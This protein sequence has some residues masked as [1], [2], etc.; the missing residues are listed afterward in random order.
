MLTTGGI[1]FD[2][3]NTPYRCRIDDTDFHFSSIVYQS[4]F[5]QRVQEN[6]EMMNAQLTVKT[7]IKTDFNLL[8][9]ISLYTRIEKRG[10]YIVV[11]GVEYNCKEKATLHGERVSKIN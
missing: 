1:C 7:G 2:L 10:F 4:K 9:D 5:A 3:E 8:C 6:R 11:K